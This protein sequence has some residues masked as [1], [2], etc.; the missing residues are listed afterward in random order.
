MT[1]AIGINAGL[2]AI[3]AADTR[4]TYFHP[5]SPFHDDNSSK[6]S[7]TTMGLITGTGFVQL[8]D[9]VKSR[10]STE[11]ITNTNTVL[12][13]I[14]EAREEI[15]LSCKHYSRVDTSIAQ[16]G[17]IFS[18]YTFLNDVSTLRLGLYHENLSPDDFVLYGPGDPAIIYPVELTEQEV[19]TIHPNIINEIVIPRD[20]SEIQS[21]IQQNIVKLVALI[22]ALLPYCQSISNR[23]Q[24][25]IHQNG[26]MG[27]SEI[28]DIPDE[29]QISGFNIKLE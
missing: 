27:I 5:K 25:G 7:K 9:L 12:D 15:R 16:T 14:K 29:N 2:Y 8:L 13:V 19:K 3:L 26:Q 6:V 23:F 22:K 4:T 21:S 20:Q 24:I 18:Y 11:T 1:I 10:L 17:W 28:V